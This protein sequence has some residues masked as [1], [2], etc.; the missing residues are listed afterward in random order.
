MPSEPEGEDET[1]AFEQDTSAP[2][3]PEDETSALDDNENL[4][5]EPEGEDETAASKQGTSETDEQEDDI[6]ALGDSENLPSEPADEDETAA[7]EQD[8]SATDEPEDDI[9]TEEANDS[10]AAE[11]AGEE[12]AATSE[13]D[14]PVIDEQESDTSTEEANESLASE[15]TGEDDSATSGQDT[16]VI[17]EQGADSSAVDAKDNLAS[18]PEVEDDA[19]ASEFDIEDD[20]LEFISPDNSQITDDALEQALAE[21]DNEPTDQADIPPEFEGAKDESAK[22]ELDLADINALADFDD[23]EL[24]NALQNFV[25]DDEK[26]NDGQSPTSSA[27]PKNKELDDFPELGDWLNDVDDDDKE[28]FEDLASAS[29]DDMLQSLDDDLD[30]DLAQNLSAEAGQSANKQAGKDVDGAVDIATLLQ[31]SDL[32]DT[33][34]QDRDFLDVDDLLNDSLTA[35][36]LP[37]KALDLDSVMGEFSGAQGDVDHVDVDSDDGFGAKLDLAHAYIEIGETESA[38]ELLEEIIEYGHPPQSDE[39]KRVLASL[40]GEA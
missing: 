27:A 3:E 15:L 19:G 31:E 6:S 39:A 4:P 13:H 24:E 33:D 18:E 10:L 5:S 7:F 36:P 12:E 40:T 8:S 17:D 26:T 11:L 20:D 34:E 25:L 28:V 37:E 30:D 29:F 35:D 22:S 21:F 16:H 14:T 9:S 23:D 32:D 2:D 1:A 38:T